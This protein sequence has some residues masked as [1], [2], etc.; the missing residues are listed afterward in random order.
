MERDKRTRFIKL[1]I[2]LSLLHI[3]TEDEEGGCRH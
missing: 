3:L 2:Q 1:L